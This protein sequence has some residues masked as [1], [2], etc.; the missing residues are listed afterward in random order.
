MPRTRATPPTSVYRVLVTLQR[1]EPAIWRR[2][3]LPSELRLGKLHRVLHCVFDWEGYHLHQF[4]V[5]DTLYGVPDPEWGNALPMID[6]RSVP[7][8]RVLTQ[9]GDTMVYEY[10]VGDSWRHDVVLEQILPSDPERASLVC[11]AGARARPPEDVG[12]VWGYADFLQAIS[13]LEHAEHKELLTWVGGVFD[14][15]GC[16]VSM[17]NRQLQ[18]VR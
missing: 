16:D 17:T 7:L 18:R 15:E 14:P 8:S 5:G 1:I 10:D 3:V 9:V 12:G 13:D 2:L 6:E 4:V 11:L